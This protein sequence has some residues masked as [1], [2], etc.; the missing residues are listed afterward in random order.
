[1]RK[2]SESEEKARVILGR[3]TT[4]QISEVKRLVQDVYHPNFFCIIQ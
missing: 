1:M 4:E 3:E 2:P